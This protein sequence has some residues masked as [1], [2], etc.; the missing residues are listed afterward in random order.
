MI[1]TC[2]IQIDLNINSKYKNHPVNM[3]I[4]IDKKLFDDNWIYIHSPNLE[5]ARIDDFTNFSIR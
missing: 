3:H 5:M 4:T 1:M 2:Q